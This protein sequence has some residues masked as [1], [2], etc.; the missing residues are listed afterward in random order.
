M[1]TSAPDIITY[2][3]VPLAVLGVL[4]ILYS[5]L[6][7]IFIQRSIRRV[8][9][10]NGLLDSSITR[11][12]MMSGIVEVE[13][14]RC[15][16]TPLDREQDPEYWKVSSHQVSLKG[17]SW[18][19][20]HWNRLVTGRQLY[21]CQF[22][23][24]LRVPQ[25]DIDFEE[26]IAFLLDRGATP[27]AKGWHTLKSVGLWT[28]TNTALL[29]PPRGIPGTAL[30]V[31]PP[32]NSEGVLSLTV[33]W[34]SAW[35]RRDAASLP[36]FWMRLEEPSE[37]T[38]KPKEFSDERS[39]VA[40]E[41]ITR[42]PI[43]EKPPEWTPAAPHEKETTVPKVSATSVQETVVDLPSRQTT[44]VASSGDGGHGDESENGVPKPSL[45][46]A[47]SDLKMNSTDL[48]IVESNSVRFQTDGEKH[49]RRVLFENDGLLTD[50][51]RNLSTYSTAA[52]EWF[53]CGASAL[54]QS[55]DSGLW[56]FTIPPTIAQFAQKAF[57]PSGVMV[58]LDILGE[59]DIPPCFSPRPNR[60]ADA[61]RFHRQHMERVQQEQLERT[62]NPA[63]AAESR[64]IRQMRQSQQMMDDQIQAQRE[65]R[66]YEERRVAEALNS[67]RL[68][69]K[70]V[71]EANLAYLIK[72]NV[73]P[74][75]YTLSDL[76][77]AVLYLMILDRERA[78]W[79]A[80]I[81]DRWSGWT[82]SVGMTRPHLVF[83]QDH[84]LEFCYASALVSIVQ[85]MNSSE[86]KAASDM[87][88]CIRLWK[89]VRLG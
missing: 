51:L 85:K 1:P 75:Y 45:I 55:L 88:E 61:M 4:P 19:I 37:L 15:T 6:R 2:I 49:I 33:Y 11:G 35:D 73:I 77:H 20:F 72:E 83:L 16:I 84:K 31:A 36:P 26:L 60:Q 21:R 32:D 9:S 65:L 5:F 42:S 43:D 22:K 80:E 14:P 44:L 89:R 70:A 23:D 8:L 50:G 76:V 57:I 86:D 3:G 81:L 38:I 39:L 67:Q 69:V 29:R 82:N 24:E 63:Q 48:G 18:S 12:S 59:E 58:A 40:D 7:T 28:P 13:M 66:E 79:I 10:H 27:D 46:V 62:M 52:N 78:K 53:V 54:S 47:I 64:R 74:E 68:E 30:K 17:G 87:L 71:L 56:N 41:G 34:E 25:A